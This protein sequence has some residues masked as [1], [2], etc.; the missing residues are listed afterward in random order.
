MDTAATIHTFTMRWPIIDM[1]HPLNELLGQAMQDLARELRNRLWQQAEPVEWAITRATGGM[2]LVATV[3][4][5]LP[6]RTDETDLAKHRRRREP[7]LCR[8]DDVR[9]LLDQGETHAAIA[10]RLGITE[11]A[12]DRHRYVRSRSAS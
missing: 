5:A 12:V 4:V 9:E 7:R 2:V 1:R 8:G 11:A 3:A 6:D 10:A